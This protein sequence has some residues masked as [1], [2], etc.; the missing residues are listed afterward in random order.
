MNIEELRDNC[1]AIKGSAESTP[2][3]D[4]NV[5][6]FKIMEKMFAYIPLAPKDGRFRVYLKC[7]PDRSVELREQYCGITDSEWSSLLWN[8]VHLE[9]DVP[10]KLIAELIIHSADEVIKKLPKKKQEEYSNLNTG[11]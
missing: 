11:D 3:I 7:N 10:D 4:Q 2:F 8:K 5:L 6:V 1:L 9:S